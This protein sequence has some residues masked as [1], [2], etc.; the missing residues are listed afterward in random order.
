MSEQLMRSFLQRRLLSFR[1]RRLLV[2]LLI[3]L[4]STG[5]RVQVNSDGSVARWYISRDD[6][7][8]WLDFCDEDLE[9]DN[10]DLPSDDPFYGY[11]SKLDD[12]LQSIINDYNNVNT[13][14]LRFANYPENPDQ[15]GDPEEGDSE[16]TKEDARI[17]TIEI[18]FGDLP[19][20]ASGQ[21]SYKTNN[22][23]CDSIESDSYYKD[24]CS[25][26]RIHSC[27]IKMNKSYAE[28]SISG[29]I[30]TLT[31]ELGH[32]VG[33]LHNHDTHL[34]IMSYLADPEEILRLQMDDK[35]G[36]TYLYPVEDDYAE[37]QPTLGLTGCD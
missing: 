37:E 28:E 25:K 19:Y 31:H 11:G 7:T 16:F 9:F 2:I 27:T 10:Y 8:I 36:L 24:Y 14:Y 6:P 26:T 20:Y 15:P 18:C 34:S 17:R 3:V 32:C 4:V 1:W 33:F 23:A 30:H 35:M 13:S 5:F 21:A 29:F 12:V 22:D